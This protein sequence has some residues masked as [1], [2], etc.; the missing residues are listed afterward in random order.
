MKAKKTAHLDPFKDLDKRARLTLRQALQDGSG[1]GTAPSVVVKKL[2]RAGLVRRTGHMHEPQEWG[3]IVHRWPIFALTAEGAEIARKIVDK[4]YG[5]TGVAGVTSSAHSTI[6]SAAQL[7]AE[8][9]ASLGKLRSKRGAVAAADLNVLAQAATFGD[10]SVNDLAPQARTASRLSKTYLKRVRAAGA[11]V[12]G[13]V[14]RGLL[15]AGGTYGEK[16][17]VTATGQQ[18][19]INAGYATNAAGEWIK[20]G[21]RRPGWIA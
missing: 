7:D 3:K 1:T 13:L 17:T 19:L 12:R 8:I 5:P 11:R 14:E 2:E 15:E 16:Y 20:A 21:A 10:V 4:L 18:A 6:K 9:A